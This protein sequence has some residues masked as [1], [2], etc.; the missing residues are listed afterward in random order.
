MH[1][2]AN[3]LATVSLLFIAPFSASQ[4]H[5]PFTITT[6]TPTKSSQ[7]SCTHSVWHN[8][9]IPLTLDEVKTQT[10]TA[11]IKDTRNSIIFEMFIASESMDH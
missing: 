1:G 6:V 11:K 5:T 8:T 10:S 3:Y 2:N 7:Q 4:C 9:T